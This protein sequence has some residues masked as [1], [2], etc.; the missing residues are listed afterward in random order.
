M[1]ELELSELVF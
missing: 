1:E